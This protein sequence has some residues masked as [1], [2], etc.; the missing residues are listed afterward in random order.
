MAGCYDL[1]VLGVLFDVVSDERAERN[2]GV[3]LAAAVVQRG[4]GER[5]AEATAFAGFVHLGVREGDSAVSAPIG[6]EADEASAEAELV[7]TFLGHVDDLRVLDRSC[8]RRL[9]LVRAA[10]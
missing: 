5:G 6:R 1:L 2:D 9:E 3:S 7:P 10:E 8:C 4:L